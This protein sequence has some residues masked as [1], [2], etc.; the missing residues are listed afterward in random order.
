MAVGV[1]DLKTY[2]TIDRDG[3]S[4]YRAFQISK[5][6]IIKTVIFDKNGKY[7]VY[8]G[9]L[10]K[11]IWAGYPNAGNLKFS[12][13]SIF[14]PIQIDEKITQIDQI[15]Q[16]IMENDFSLKADKA[17]EEQDVKAHV[18]GDQK[19]KDTYIYPVLLKSGNTLILNV[20]TKTNEKSYQLYIGST[21]IEHQL[22]LHETF[23]KDGDGRDKIRVACTIVNKFEDVDPILKINIA[24]L[25]QLA[26]RIFNKKLDDEKKTNLQKKAPLKNRVIKYLR[27]NKIHIAIAFFAT[28]SYL[29]SYFATQYYLTNLKAKKA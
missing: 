20:N 10:E 22:R 26:L 27:E 9:S 12:F 7:Q 2:Q 17:L 6:H 28:T 29:I 1:G 18:I 19:F 14:T 5:D 13:R 3:Q 15:A 25:D 21:Q 11:H 4:E 8:D 16:F 24:S 23:G